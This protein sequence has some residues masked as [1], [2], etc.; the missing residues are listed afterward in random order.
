MDAPSQPRFDVEHLGRMPYGQALE[1]QRAV[2]ARVLAG[3][4]AAG[5]HV[6]LLVE[7]P[8][9][10]T[11]TKR[12]DAQGHVLASAEA[13]VAAGVERCETD[14][15]GDVTY[16]GPGQAVIY[17]IVDLQRLG[18]GIH[19]YIRALEEA[20]IRTCAAFGV[21]AHREQGA[22]G[23]WTG[24]ASGGPAATRKVAAIG[25]RV[26]R[27]VT[28]H[29]MA[30]NVRPDLAHFGLIVPCGLHGRQVTSLERELGTACPAFGIASE[31]LASE[32]CAALAEAA[33]ARALTRP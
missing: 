23:V 19:A 2:H 24:D 17:P 7:H 1:A 28:M 10:V 16:H 27:G 32:A 11:V 13:L 31:R 21:A 9:V 12:H 6:V 29:G 15:G 14:R 18:I 30:L 26:S 20:A 25:V 33:A 22:T 5:A 8:A 3:R 4:E